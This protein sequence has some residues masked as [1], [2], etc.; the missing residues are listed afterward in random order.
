MRRTNRTNLITLATARR[1]FTLVELLI[2]VT[3]MGIAGALVIPSMSQVGALRGQTA[4]RTIV[5]DITYAQSEALAHQRRYVIVFG[6]IV[7]SDG[8]SD[9]A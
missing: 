1:A 5:A 4:V 6:Q 7:E 2:A 9:C 8:A 3:V